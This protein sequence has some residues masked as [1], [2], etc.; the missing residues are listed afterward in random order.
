MITYDAVLKEGVSLKA[1]GSLILM[2]NISGEPQPRVSWF[3]GENQVYDGSDGTTIESGSD[4][5]R[6]TIKPS[7][8]EHS[9][10]FKVTAENKHGSDEASFNV[11]VIGMSYSVFLSYSV[12]SMCHNI[13]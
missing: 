1:G 9:G 13:R 4:F 3:L 8:G 7:R 6:L 2:V 5:S 10:V 11:T 12:L